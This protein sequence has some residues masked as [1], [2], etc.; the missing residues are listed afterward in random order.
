M[1]LKGYVFRPAF[2]RPMHG[3]VSRTGWY[4]AFYAIASPLF[5]VLR[6]IAPNF[7][8]TTEEMGR[9]MIHVAKSG[10]PKRILESRDIAGAARS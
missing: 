5:P 2:I 9:A 8:T 1:P 10:Y 3:I 6:A 4:R 7:V